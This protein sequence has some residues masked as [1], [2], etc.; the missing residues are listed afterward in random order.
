MG[1]GEININLEINESAMVI[2]RV[3]ILEY[4]QGEDNIL[5]LITETI[6]QYIKPELA[7]EKKAT[8]SFVCPKSNYTIDI[9]T[10]IIC[11]RTEGEERTYLGTDAL[12]SEEKMSILV[13]PLSS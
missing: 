2:P 7:N 9:N 8:S 12:D 1:N 11:E 3:C 4:V 5:R 6:R 10:R 13:F